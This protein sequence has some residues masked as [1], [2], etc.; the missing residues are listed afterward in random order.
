MNK[1]KEIPSRGF[2]V[3]AVESLHEFKLFILVL[4]N[5]RNTVDGQF[6][7]KG[8]VALLRERASGIVDEQT[9]LTCMIRK[10]GKCSGPRD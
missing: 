7:R 1:N 5:L 6:P 9:W 8:S 2:P 3:W 4:F 10:M